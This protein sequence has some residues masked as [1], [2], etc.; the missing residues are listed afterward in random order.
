M[1]DWYPSTPPVTDETHHCSLQG[2]LPEA[3]V[4]TVRRIIGDDRLAADVLVALGSMLDEL[5]TSPGAPSGVDLVLR[6]GLD[7]LELALVHGEVR[8]TLVCTMC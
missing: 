3:L 4:R 2:P 5:A 1:F 6:A 8:E 7:S